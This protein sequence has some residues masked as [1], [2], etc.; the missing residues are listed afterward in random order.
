MAEYLRSALSYLAGSPSCKTENEFVGSN[1]LVG[2]QH[3]RIKRVVA[4]GGFGVVYEAHDSVKGTPYALKRILSHD[5]DTSN[6]I[7]QEIALLKRLSGHP[8]IM[9]FYHAASVCKEK[10]KGVSA[11]FLI[12]TELC[13]GGPL[14]HYLPTPHQEPPLPVS[15]ILQIVYQTCRAVQHMHNQC[16]P[17]IHRDL[18]VDNLLL[19][20]DFIIKLCDFGSASTTS[21]SP[22]H[23]WSS[24]QRLSV[25]EELERFTTPMY[26]A[27]EMLDL[28]LNHPIGTASDIWALGC[29]LFYLT[30]TYHPFEDSAKLA[31]LN[32]NYQLPTAPSDHTIFHNLIRQMLLINPTQRPNVTEVLGELSELASVRELRVSGPISMFAKVSKRRGLSTTSTVINNPCATVSPAC[33]HTPSDPKFSSS[34]PPEDNTKIGVYTCK[35]SVPNR[36]LLPPRTAPS[37]PSTS[38]NEGTKESNPS[39]PISSTQH[40]A[41]EPCHMQHTTSGT[42]PSSMFGMLKGGAGTFIKNLRDASSKVLETVSSSLAAE[43]DFQL[44][45]SRIAVMSNPS[46]GGIEALSSGNPI[47][48]VH[49]MLNSR[50]P[51]SYAVY[52][53][54]PRPYR[55]ERWFDGRVSH[56]ALEPH[57]APPLKSL[58]EL[59]LNARL[60]LSQSPKNIC[61]VHCTDG[62]SLSAVLVCSLLCFCRLFDN[63]SPALQLFSSK[64]GNPRL[65]ASQVRYIGYVAQMAHQRGPSPH[66][67]PLKLISLTVAPVPTFNK[68]KNGC[69]PYVEVY[70]G[71]SQ[72]LSTFTDYESLKSYV[73][74]DGKIE[75]MLN[76]ISVMGDLTVIIY[77]C[78]S[79]FAGRSKVAAVKIAQFQLHT[80]YVE[81][82]QTE[83]IYFKS[84][85]DHLDSSSGFGGFTSRYAESFNVTMEF[86]VSPNERPRHGKNL[87]YPWE[88]LP[89]IE[90][91][92]P[93]LCVSDDA[94]LQRLLVDFGRFNFAAI[95]DATKISDASPLH[96]TGPQQ[97]SDPVVTLASGLPPNEERDISRPSSVD[98][99]NTVH[100]V[101]N[102]DDVAQTADQLSSVVEDLLGF[103]TAESHLYREPSQTSPE[104]PILIDVASHPSNVKV[105]AAN[106]N[107][108][109]TAFVDDFL[110][111]NMPSEQ[112]HSD[113]SSTFDVP[114]EGVHTTEAST[115]PFNLFTTTTDDSSLKFTGAP[116]S[117]EN[118]AVHFESAFDHRHLSASVSVTNLAASKTTPL[119][120]SASY[121][122]LSSTNGT[123]TFKPAHTDPFVDL[124]ELFG[125]QPQPTGT[126]PA[127]TNQTLNGNFTPTSTD[128]NSA[129]NSA[130]TTIPPQSS[131][132]NIF[133][134]STPRPPDPSSSGA[135]FTTSSSG[136]RPKVGKDAF[137]DLLGD[138]GSASNTENAG[139]PKTVNQMRREQKAISTDPEELMVQDWTH[140]KDRN[141]RAL[142][143]SLPAILWEGVRWNPVGITDLLHPDQVKRQ[144]RNAARA[145]HP[146]KWMNTE[147]EKLAR[148]IFVELN[149]AMAEFEKDPAPTLPF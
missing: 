140:G 48:D 6:L 123:Q 95:S 130:T 118:P 139:Q 68:S 105:N 26:R 96:P 43:L 28:Y 47:E 94:E 42:G 84:D 144:Y 100:E 61:V 145:V 50:Y 126:V 113:W 5:K 45:T 9:R 4:E 63:A 30:C 38:P 78:R 106:F 142:L 119:H 116:K 37:V 76:G 53:L 13:R 31:I 51:N 127:S 27:P 148:M 120:P 98:L 92:R 146:D 133:G 36:P 108:P 132:P 3:L 56:R 46:E 107:L 124:F 70:E 88:M 12:V 80:G 131:R 129:F 8:N 85:L 20:E 23:T 115:N 57:R 97:T 147:Y 86:I 121:T 73:L 66:H 16:P 10:V 112:T 15:V 64:R 103:H 101:Q 71:K 14:T 33:G 125:H 62:R 65:N 40:S 54:S 29:I 2:N 60:W 55:S 102:Q 24:L 79:S 99:S 18:K 74:E 59:C 82:D 128:T 136:A 90:S 110:N 67:R 34:F 111:L 44:I 77:H 58:V 49:N 21:Y 93:S 137:S 32:A 117:P 91:L 25:Q 17:I 1:I 11:E 87:V 41:S 83:L 138:F 39:T 19:S 149:D 35:P 135:G 69:R 81:A 104:P 109:S 143:C 114:R 75:F 22:D 141:L 72:V 7:M 89:P 52:N 122:S 134:S